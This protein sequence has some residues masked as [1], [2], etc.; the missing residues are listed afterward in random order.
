MG[1]LKHYGCHYTYDFSDIKRV[2]SFSTNNSSATLI[3]NVRERLELHGPRSAGCGK[4]ANTYQKNV[5]YWLE[6]EGTTWK[7]NEYKVGS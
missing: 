2:V 7:I 5:T 6:K 3:I 4:G 1:W